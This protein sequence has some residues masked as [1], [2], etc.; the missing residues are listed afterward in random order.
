MGDEVFCPSLNE[1]PTV[2]VCMQGRNNLLRQRFQ[3]VE[4]KLKRK[5]VQPFDLNQR[6]LKLGVG[7][8]LAN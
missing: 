8:K 2:G 7:G 3:F 6:V 1:T 4:W 5:D